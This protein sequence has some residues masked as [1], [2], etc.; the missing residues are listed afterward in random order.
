MMKDKKE[1]IKMTSLNLRATS[2]DAERFKAQSVQLDMSFSEYAR[3]A[4]INYERYLNTDSLIKSLEQR[5]L[6]RLF[7]LNSAIAGLTDVEIIEASERYK[8]LLLKKHRGA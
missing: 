5:L 8:E 3:E 6:K 1:K 7:K 2:Y 4:L